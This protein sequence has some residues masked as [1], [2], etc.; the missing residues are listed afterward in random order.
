MCR[1]YV[2][3]QTIPHKSTLKY[4]YIHGETN[5]LQSKTPMFPRQDQPQYS[6]FAGSDDDQRNGNG[7]NSATIVTNS[8]YFVLDHEAVAKEISVSIPL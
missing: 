4:N 5:T 6:V 3:A 7:N 8:Q 2:Q 1:Y